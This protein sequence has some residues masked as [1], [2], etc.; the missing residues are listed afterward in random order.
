MKNFIYLS[1]LGLLFFSCDDGGDDSPKE[2]ENVAP[3]VPVLISPVNN[4][5]CVS[6]IVDFEWDKSK[7]NGVLTYE[8]QI[9]E[10]N[11]F[12]NVIETIES[13]SNFQDIELEKNT[14]YYWRIK[15]TDDEGLSSDYSSTYKFYTAGDVVVNHLPFAPELIA[16][17]MNTIISETT[18]NLKWN[19]SDVDENDELSY[20]IYFGT[21]NPPIE[22]ITG[23]S[24]AK[25]LE[26]PLESSKEYFWKVVVKDNNGGETVGQVWKFKTS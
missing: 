26:V 22:K 3:T 1:I 4:K 15:A 18:A 6:N 14:A 20:D 11:Q 13:T 25:T 24:T 8:L 23:N 16:P 19:A 17:I 10:D 5:L 21:V 7:D 2:T 12:T 9:A